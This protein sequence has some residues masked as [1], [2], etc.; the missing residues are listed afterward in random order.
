MGT[1]AASAL[2]AV[3]RPAC[4]VL[5][6]LLIARVPVDAQTRDYVVLQVPGCQYTIPWAVNDRGDVVGNAMS[7][8]GGVPD[9]AFLY[10]EG[11][12]AAIDV[13][14]AVFTTPTDINDRGMVVGY[15][16][17]PTGE[18]GAFSL[19]R[20]EYQSLT[21]PGVHLIPQGINNRGDI[22]GWVPTPE[23]YQAFLL[24]KDGVFTI[25]QGE[26]DLEG[27]QAWEIN[28]SGLIVGSAF[29]PSRGL[30]SFLYRRGESSIAD[31]PGIFYAVNDRGDVAAEIPGSGFAVYRQGAPLELNH[32][33]TSYTIFDLSNRWAV[34]ALGGGES[35]YLL[36]LP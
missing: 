13:P 3:I 25:L 34:G 6:A 26:G 23:A 2:L 22:T 33:E 19:W 8:A 11:V 10:R 27:L 16:R 7:C 4:V 9:F 30:V 5:F 17:T 35:G 12:Y 31:L 14:G 28:S 1:P 36:R 18:G 24:T 29:S 21:V 32:P 20:G 15:F